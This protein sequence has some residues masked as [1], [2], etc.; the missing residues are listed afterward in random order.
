MTV[1]LG[2]HGVI[3]LERASGSPV[4]GTVDIG[5][6]NPDKNRFSFGD[7]DFAGQFISGDEIDLINTDNENLLFIAGHNFRD[8]RGFVYVD[9][10]GGIRLYDS[11]EASIRGKSSE[12]LALVT[13]SKAQTVVIQTRNNR[14]QYLAQVKQFEFTSERETID[15][16]LLGDQF[17][18][19]YEAGLIS[20]Q[21]RIDCFWDHK[22]ELCDPLKCSDSAELPV[23]LAQLCVRLTQGA[24]FFGRFF[25]YTSGSD[26]SRASTNSVWYEAECIVTN[27]SVT[28]SPDELIESSIDF[29]TTGPI[30]LLIGIAPSYLLKEVEETKLLQEDGSGLLLAGSD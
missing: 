20:G 1:Y 17:R 30:R 4:T 8:W 12:A 27:V 14:Y 6:V 5:D 3:E 11:F 19:R 25:I 13:P 7:I 18:K 16:T 21:G 9:I 10:L 26:D 28:V 22:Q 24:N 29:V 2:D 23:Y 15:L